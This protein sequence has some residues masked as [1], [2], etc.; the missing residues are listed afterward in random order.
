MKRVFALLIMICTAFALYGCQPGTDMPYNG[1]VSFHAVTVSVPEDFIRD[2]TRSNSDLWC[3]EKGFYDQIIILSRDDMDGDVSASLDSYLAYMI[4][5][6]CESNRTTFMQLDAVHS[7]YTQNDQYCQ[8]MLFAYHGSL[9]AIA[10]RG[11]TE[12]DFQ[13]LL[14]SVILAAA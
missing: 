9:Y 13:S 11:G 10:L 8:E 5:Q 6:G 2:S 12:E 1:D 7:T 3:F 14:D 4:E